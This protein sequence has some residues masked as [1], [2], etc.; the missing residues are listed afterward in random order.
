MHIRLIGVPLPKIDQKTIENRSEID[1]KSVQNRSKIGPK[2]ASEPTSLPTPIF[3]RFG[4]VSGAILEPSWGPLGGQVGAKLMQ[5]SI[6]GGLGRRSKT[7]FVFDTF[8]VRFFAHFGAIW[9]SKMEPK[10]LPKR[11]QEPSS[12]KAK[13][14]KKTIGF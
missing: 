7:N 9:G 2:S 10:S 1:P 14:L 12:K 4:T 6:F 3:D 5:K 8:Q 13:N 11:S